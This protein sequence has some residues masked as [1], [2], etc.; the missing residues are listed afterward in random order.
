MSPPPEETSPIAKD[1]LRQLLS[2]LPDM[3]LRLIGFSVLPGSS[4]LAQYNGVHSI[5]YL[6]SLSEPDLFMAILHELGH[7][8]LHPPGAGEFAPERLDESEERLVHNATAQACAALG[9]HEYVETMAGH[10][11]PR[12][13]LMP[14]VSELHGQR[15]EIAAFLEAV[16]HDY[17]QPPAWPSRSG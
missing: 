11:A 9:L 3:G 17:Q 8:Y 14:V 7:A 12:H 15:D 5:F 1:L 16:V 10:G 2:A 4:S 13:L 6:D